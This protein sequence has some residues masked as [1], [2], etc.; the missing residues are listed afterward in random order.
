M[1]LSRLSG[2]LLVL[3]VSALARG[4]AAQ[5]TMQFMSLD[6]HTNLIAHLSRPAG[7]APRP[8]LVLMHGCSGLLNSSGR[9][10]PIYRAWLRALDFLK[11][12]LEAH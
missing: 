10:L 6:G 3:M 2:W 4:A 11:L 9:M 1:R 12:H 5:E 7:E 8:A